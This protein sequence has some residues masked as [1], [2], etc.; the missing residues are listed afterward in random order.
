MILI[1]WLNYWINYILSEQMFQAISS[2]RANKGR[3]ETCSKPGRL[4]Q[5]SALRW[6]LSYLNKP[7]STLHTKCAR[8]SRPQLSHYAEMIPDDKMSIMIFILTPQSQ[9]YEFILRSLW[10]KYPSHDILCRIVWFYFKYIQVLWFVSSFI[11]FSF[12][13]LA[14][15][16]WLFIWLFIWFIFGYWR[17]QW[18]LEPAW[19]WSPNSICIRIL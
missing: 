19:L 8:H 16:L 2:H 1:S 10:V 3:M 4:R 17:N 13:D 6:S 12:P 15:L 18:F 5:H 9:H 14:Y 7:T 11:G